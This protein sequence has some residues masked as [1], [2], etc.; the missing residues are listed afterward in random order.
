V[1]SIPVRNLPDEVH[2]APR[3]LAARYGRSTEA[4][5]RDI[6]ERAVKPARRVRFGDAH[7]WQS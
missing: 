1:T 2:H 6:L 4:E 7:P 3:V 5:I